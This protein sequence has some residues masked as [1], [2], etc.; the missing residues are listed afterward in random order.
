MFLF[1]VDLGETRLKELL[2]KQAQLNA[3]LDLYK[4]ETQAVAEAPGAQEKPFRR[5][6]RRAFG[7]RVRASRLR[8]SSALLFET[9]PDSSA[10]FSLSYSAIWHGLKN[11]VRLLFKLEAPS[12]RLEIG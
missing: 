1:G 6:S 10:S 8:F 3:A 11:D 12:T 7:P 5:A 2:A 9:D 4:H